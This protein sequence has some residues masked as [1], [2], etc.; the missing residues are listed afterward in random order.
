MRKMVLF[1]AAVLAAG[2]ATAANPTKVTEAR[3]ST[4]GL[5]AERM[6]QQVF[7]KT[8]VALRMND[9][10]NVVASKQLKDGSSIDLVRGNDGHLYKVLNRSLR[11]SDK[12]APSKSCINAPAVMKADENATLFEGFESYEGLTSRGWVPEGWSQVSKTNPPHVA[13]EGEGTCL[14][15]EATKGDGFTSAYSGTYV[16]RVQV[17]MADFTAD[18]ITFAE[19]QDEWLITKA[20]TPKT[21]DYL[22]FQLYYSPC[23]TLL[24]ES[25]MDFSSVNNILEVLVTT[26]DGKTWE[27]V[28]DV[29]DDARSYTVD[30]LWD[31]GRSFVRPY[32]PMLVNIS[33]YVGKNIKIAFRYYGIN[34][35]SMMLDDV[36]VGEATPTA[37]V[38]APNAVFPIGLSLEGYNLSDGSGN[39]LNLALAPYKTSL[40]WTNVSPAY[41]SC[42]WTYPDEEG[43]ETTSSSK[44]LE[45]PEYGFAQ[46]DAPSLVTKIGS[47]TSDAAK[48]YD[49]VQYGGSVMIRN[50]DSYLSFDA[51]MYDLNRLVSKKAKFSLARD[52]VFGMGATSDATWNQLLKTEGM[53]VTGMGMFIPQPAAPYTLSSANAVVYY[54]AGKLTDKSQLKATVYKVEDDGS[55]TAMAEGYCSPS[56]IYKADDKSY[57]K[58]VFYFEREI[59]GLPT[60]AELFVDYPIVIQFSANLAEG[61]EFDFVNA[62]DSAPKEVENNVYVFFNDASGTRKMIDTTALS[63]EDGSAAAGLYA[64][65]DAT[66]S[67]LRSDEDAFEAKPAGESKTFDLDSYYNL[68]NSKGENLATATGEGLGD[69]YTVSFA[70]GSDTEPA[71]MTVTVNAL[72]E[73]TDV[74]SSYFDVEVFGMMKRFYVAQ[75]SEAGVSDLAVSA[76][77][78]FVNGGNIVVS[79]PKATRVAVYNVAGQKVAEQAFAGKATIKASDFAKGIYV[80]KFNDNTVLKLTK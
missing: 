37:A 78:A 44:N 73:G 7:S 6:N 55:F 46:Y 43:N 66:Y 74:R 64:S 35:E 19:Q 59:D 25:T 75:H 16:E 33:K 47:K 20:I 51:A 54:T 42:T 71:K 31:D 57:P 17:S 18:P 62:F 67:W 1:S 60:Q 48:L 32:H 14:V 23:F 30:E 61:E 80:L 3:M 69:W 13:P 4:E 38:T 70:N 58:A 29:L 34:G 15:W 56:E 45:A 8:A 26:D 21:G 12:I 24:N 52:G 79:S 11:A 40:E 41:E 53:K 36:K 49:A 63:F 77:K 22:T 28:W 65:F 39:V 27:K 10:S 76:T 68:V 50:G 72:P 9:K 2:V 5:R